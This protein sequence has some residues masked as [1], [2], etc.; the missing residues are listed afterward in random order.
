MIVRIVKHINVTPEEFLSKTQAFGPGVETQEEALIRMYRFVFPQEWDHIRKLHGS[1]I[2]NS[3]FWQYICL[4]FMD[5]DCKVTNPRM[6]RE[7][8]ERRVVLR[9]GAWMNS[10]FSVDEVMPDD[11]IEVDLD[12]EVAEVVL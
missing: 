7:G 2:V 9:G 1:P 10:G 5:F 11:L 6:R 8:G 12:A 4:K 3:K